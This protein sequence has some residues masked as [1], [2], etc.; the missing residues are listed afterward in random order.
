MI[1]CD[2][3]RKVVPTKICCFGRW[4]VDR[5]RLPSWDLFDDCE[6]IVLERLENI[7]DCKGRVSK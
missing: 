4:I 3:C 1:V 5:N 6:K 7:M 2:Y